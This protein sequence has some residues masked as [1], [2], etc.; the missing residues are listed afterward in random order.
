MKVARWVN[1]LAIGVRLAVGGG[2]SALIRLVLGAIGVATAVVA[3]LGAASTTTILEDSQHRRTA[4]ELVTAGP[5]GSPVEP[6]AAPAALYGWADKSSFRGEQ[7]EIT[8]LHATRPDH[9]MPPGVDRLPGPGEVVLSPALARLLDSPEGELLR[10]RFQGERVGELPKDVLGEPTTLKAYVGADA[11]FTEPGSN[12]TPVERFGAAPG[13]GGGDG[14][15]RSPE[16][17]LLALLGAVVL[18]LPVFTFVAT[19]SRIAGA[20]RD[21][22]LSALRLVG[23]DARQ[24]HRIAAAESLVSA[25]LGLVLGAGVF[26][27]AR[28]LVEGAELFGTSFYATDLTP[29]LLGGALVVLT[30]PAVALLATLVALRRTIVE[31]LGVV[32]QTK[33]VRRRLWWRLLL[34]VAGAGTVFAVGSGGPLEDGSRALVVVGSALLLVGVPVLLPW[35]VERFAG[36]VRGGA[37]SWQL[38]I[39][40]LQLDSG[41]SARVVGGVAVVLTGAI[42]LLTVL[43]ATL[44][45]VAA[46][47]SSGSLSST[48][49]AAVDPRVLADVEKS[50]ATVPAVRDVHVVRLLDGYPAGSGQS[51]S[52]D[53]VVVDCSLVTQLTTARECSDGQAFSVA[54]GNAVLRSGAAV[55]FR[56]S[57]TGG[58]D[59]EVVGTWTVPG[60]LD[61]AELVPLP[62]GGLPSLGMPGAARRGMIIATPGAIGGA[63][64]PV[65]AQAT[66]RAEVDRPTSDQ[67][68][69]I[70]NAFAAHPWRTA[71]YPGGPFDAGF[72]RKS[73]ETAQQALYTG[74]ALTLFVAGFSLLVLAFEQIQ[75]RRKPLAMLVAS[76]VGLGVLARSLLWQVAV[77][78]VLGVGVSV[79]TGLGMAA[80]ILR[81]AGL[82][83][84]VDW[85]GVGA[86]AGGAALVTFAVTAMTLPFLR[87]ATRLTS[88]RAE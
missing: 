2:R 12:G 69:L 24:V 26:L 41:T 9:P 63:K 7:V 86:L 46:P 64:L 45:G 10:P 36:R 16:L 32:R 78:I 52:D 85:L 81:I 40:R 22:R 61:K 59:F 56:R 88:L 47:D 65:D 33:P 25:V 28:Q 84:S 5:G 13:G 21:R 17:M 51:P 62:P 70:R 66:L 29:D 79:L 74:A 53:I 27:V 82:P 6:G 75:E 38:A 83:L 30:V 55:E 54:E 14:D 73:M 72:E 71:V 11:S 43:T 3:L 76:G 67:L 31:P 34:V 57:P 44:E 39:R 58:P 42:A 4:D 60:R 77:P 87:S 15:G 37:P 20:Q 35:L 18:L 68:E 1:D 80:L 48:L 50:L 8:Y 19:T 49:V 23:S